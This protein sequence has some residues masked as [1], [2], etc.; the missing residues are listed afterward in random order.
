VHLKL[1]I[2]IIAV[3][4]TIL[5]AALILGVLTHQLVFN[6]PPPGTGD[7]GNKRLNE[8]TN[9]KVFSILP[10]NVSLSGQIIKTPAEYRHPAF[11]TAGWDGPSVEMIF[12]STD[13][14][15]VVYKFY[16][17]MAAETGWQPR[18]TDRDGYIDSWTKIYSDR[19]EAILILYGPTGHTY[20]LVGSTPAIF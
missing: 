1:N 15:A 11:Q 16:A 13:T 20:K 2:K 5:V 7:P 3:F 19:A 8:L 9:D 17:A 4:I 10:P 14:K 6:G 18:S 12:T